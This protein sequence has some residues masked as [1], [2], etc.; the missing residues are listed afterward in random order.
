M[1]R[2]GPKNAREFRIVDIISDSPDIA[3][4]A[5]WFPV[6]REGDT[7]F[8][9]VENDAVLH[10]AA[11]RP[12]RNT[13]TMVVEPGPGVQLSPFALA[14]RLADGTPLERVLVLG[15]QRV[16]FALPPESPRVFSIVFHVDEGGHTSGADPRILNFR[17]FSIA[18][19]RAADVFPAWATPVSGFYSLEQ[20]GNRL[21]RWVKGDARIALAP[22]AQ[23]SL[24]FDVESGP[25][26]A[27]KPFKLR[28][29][30]SDDVEIASEEIGSRSTVAVP[31]DKAKKGGTLVLKAE[32][33]GR[34]VPGDNRVMNFRI[35]GAH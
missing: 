32:G 17:I 20:D 9:W 33:G 6:E 5:G 13:I 25:G 19:D 22:A 28:V 8:R 15:K 34:V 23:K 12:L 11:L 7:A 35:F 1:L 30:D 10:V 3:L 14:I 31:L 29:F 16:T 27:S 4:G 18:V 26:L 24:R 21:F 2:N